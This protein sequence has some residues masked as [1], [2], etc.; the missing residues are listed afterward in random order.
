MIEEYKNIQEFRLSA[1]RKLKSFGITG[2]NIYLIDLF[3]LLEVVW[4]DGIAQK[5]EVDLVWDFLAHHVNTLNQIAEDEDFIT[6]E[7]AK[8]FL[9]TFLEKEPDQELLK[10]ITSLVKPVRFTTVDSPV[11][12]AIKNSILSY[13][14]DIAAATVRKYPYPVGNRVSIP[15]KNCLFEILGSFEKINTND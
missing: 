15:E 13:C 1:L 11:N 5:E 14:I 9:N 6:Y 8:N 7:E 10:T 12:D 3:P 2:K 4:A